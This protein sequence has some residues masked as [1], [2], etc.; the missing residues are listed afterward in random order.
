MHTCNFISFQRSVIT[1]NEKRAGGNDSMCVHNLFENH[2]NAFQIFKM[3]Y[4]HLPV[5]QK[6]LPLTEQRTVYLI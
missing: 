2:V 3:L 1:A 4:I 6:I 5:E